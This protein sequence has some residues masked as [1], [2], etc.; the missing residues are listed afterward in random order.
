MLSEIVGYSDTSN[1]DK[2]CLLSQV[3]VCLREAGQGAGIM[4]QRICFLIVVGS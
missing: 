2:D 4:A 1:R 3:I